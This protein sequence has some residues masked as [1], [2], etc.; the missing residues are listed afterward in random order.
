MFSMLSYGLWSPHGC[1]SP[2]PQADPVVLRIS[3]RRR[4][5]FRLRQGLVGAP[6]LSA[7]VEELLERDPAHQRHLRSVRRRQRALRVRVSSVGWRAYLELEE[8]EFDRWAH[9]ID[10]VTRWALERGRR[11]R[12]RR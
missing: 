3:D 11:S 2:N 8:A 5:P 6:R 9:A 10:R 12:G 7:Q 1:F 4:P